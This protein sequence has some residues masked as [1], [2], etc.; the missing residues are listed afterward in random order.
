MAKKT[1]P[2]PIKEAM[3]TL[4]DLRQQSGILAPDMT[5]MLGRY[6]FGDHIGENYAGKASVP[7]ETAA[8]F[9]GKLESARD[10]KSRR[11]TAYQAYLQERRA[12]PGREASRK[13][14][15]AA[16]GVDCSWQENDGAGGESESRG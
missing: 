11:W 9:L 6:G 10:V 5:T 1:E 16:G 13:G 4:D 12:Q 2:Q 14:K 8:E 3:V 15:K 7:I